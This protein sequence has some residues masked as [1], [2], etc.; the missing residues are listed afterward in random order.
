M[1]IG[2][3]KVPKIRSGGR[4]SRLLPTVMATALSLLV[5]GGCSND[6]STKTTAG[7]CGQGTQLADGL[8]VPSATGSMTCGTGTRAEGNQCVA[9]GV[10]LSCGEGT[11][12]VEGACVPTAIPPLEPGNFMP[13]MVHLQRVYNPVSNHMHLDEVRYRQSDKKLFVCSY[14]FEVLDATDPGAMKYISGA[15]GLKVTIPASGIRNNTYA[16]GTRTGGCINMSWDDTDNDVVYTTHKGNIDDPAYLG[17]WRLTP[18][19]SK[20]VATQLPMLQEP[21]VSYEGVDVANGYIYVAMHDGGF[22]VFQRNPA[23][24]SIS[25][26][27]TLGGLE[28]AIAVRV[29]GNTAYVANGLGGLA[30]IDISDP[31]QPKLLGEVVTGGQ[32]RDVR[33][34]GNYA[35]L[36]AGASGMI[37][38]DTTDL[39]SPKV[40]GSADMPGSAI[41][42][43]Y[44]AG[45]VY[46]AGWN[47]A[48]IYDVGDPTKPGF[49]GAGRGTGQLSA[50]DE[51]RLAAM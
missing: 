13:P 41:R 5:G 17:A 20:L 42:L 3:K 29:S 18:S 19:G 21:G 9:D 23:D 35:Y 7:V 28:D 43:D 39:T 27:A 2:T 49:L 22:G 30:T 12:E 50:H 24:D 46:V 10:Q 15:N 47:D 8:C 26:I 14:T 40:V 36:A 37:V 38:V 32:V 51:Q 6:D 48:R 16:S 33:V 25:R 45:R 1:R 31:T 11:A 4:S 44:N 34:S